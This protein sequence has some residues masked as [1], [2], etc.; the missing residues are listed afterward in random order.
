[1]Q[2]TNEGIS[3]DMVRSHSRFATLWPRL[4]LESIAALAEQGNMIRAFYYHFPNWI[5]AS[6][7]FL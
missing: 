1:V 5:G 4:G 3:M 6:I 7:F 2:E